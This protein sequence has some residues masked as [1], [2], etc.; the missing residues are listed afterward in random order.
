MALFGVL[1]NV[2]GASVC[3]SASSQSSGASEGS[4]TTTTHLISSSSSSSK[5]SDLHNRD[6]KLVLDVKTTSSGSSANQSSNTSQ[7]TVHLV[8]STMQEKQAWMS[9][10]SQVRNLNFQKIAFER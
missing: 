10:I 4:T 2:A 9:D 8:A 1:M 6:F 7:I 5:S 3:S